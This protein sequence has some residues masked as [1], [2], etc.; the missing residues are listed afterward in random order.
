MEIE[1]S[2]SGGFA[3]VPP[4]MRHVVIETEQL[5]MAVSSRLTGL[6]DDA[7]LASRPDRTPTPAGAADYRTF[8]LT[9][10]GE[11]TVNRT[12]TFTD[13]DDDPVLTELVRTIS[14]LA[15]TSGPDDPPDDPE[16]AA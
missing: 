13:L 7:D 10:T 9:V 6:V 4:A 5:Q 15:A 16:G 8:T 14:S 1:L 3:P 12:I 2:Q 11:G